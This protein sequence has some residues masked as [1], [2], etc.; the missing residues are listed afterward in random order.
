[1]YLVEE[2]LVAIRRFCGMPAPCNRRIARGAG[3]SKCANLEHCKRL[4]TLT[5]EDQ[6]IPAGTCEM[7]NGKVRSPSAS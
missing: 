1:M 5:F 2:P 4:E 3:V 6:D 7:C